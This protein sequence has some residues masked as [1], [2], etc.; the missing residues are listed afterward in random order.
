MS[1]GLCLIEFLFDYLF[2]L[3]DVLITQKVQSGIALGRYQEIRSSFS[4]T[5]L[6]H[7]LPE[8]QPSKETRGFSRQISGHQ[9]VLFL[10]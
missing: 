9:T 1:G 2:F 6:Q 4:R 8:R 5:V 7:T 10:T 3:L